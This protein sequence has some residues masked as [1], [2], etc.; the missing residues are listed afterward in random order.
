MPALIHEDQGSAYIPVT[1]PVT[2]ELHYMPI[3]Q[4]YRHLGGIMTSNATP[5]PDILLRQSRAM[6]TVRPLRKQL[7]ASV[8]I[9]VH[10]RRTLLNALAV[11]KLVHSSAAIMLTAAQH[12]KLWDRAYIQVWRALLLRKGVDDHIHAY[13]VLL[14]ADASPPPLALAKARASFLARLTNGGSQILRRMLYEHWCLH[15]SSS[16]LSQLE[17]DA[18][19]VCL[20]RPGALAPLRGQGVVEGLL[21]AL[22][23]DPK[24]WLG[25]VKQAEKAARRELEKWRLWRSQG[26]CVRPVSKEIGADDFVCH[27]CG[28]GFKLRKHLGA[29]L[30]RTHKIWSPARH[31]ALDRY[32]HACHAWLSN[33]KQV[34]FHLKR[35]DRC[36]R[37]L[38]YL[39]PP[40]TTD[41]IRQ[42]E[43]EDTARE[44]SLKKGQWA[45]FQGASQTAAYFRP[46]TPTAE[47]RLGDLDF[48]S[49]DVPLSSLTAYR[50]DTECV[51]WIEMYIQARSREG[52]RGDT[53]G[54]WLQK[55]CSGFTKNS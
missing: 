1:D 4:A 3:V 35:H 18:E 48:Y 21:D 28:E 24:W 43:R 49:E 42:V 5:K 44:R 30:A 40:L 41:E 32:R 2:R 45:S 16:W 46:L 10:L 19:A 53:R 33:I 25:Q 38:L 8:A 29:H 55:P 26:L 6:S 50:P 52:P 36:L 22:N 39:F 15:P 54:F 17:L 34:Q 11:S 37:R 14:A 12:Q 27:V 47:E 13:S 51:D 20:Y 7:F 23:Q 9:P 31:Y